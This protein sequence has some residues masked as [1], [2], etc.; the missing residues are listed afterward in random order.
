MDFEKMTKEELVAHLKWVE[1]M[2]IHMHSCYREYAKS[3][4][5]GGDLIR[6]IAY[7]RALQ[8][9][10]NGRRTMTEVERNTDEPS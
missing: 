7:G 6:E 5:I 1:H 2:L 3:A 4:G 10:Q 8:Y 9:V